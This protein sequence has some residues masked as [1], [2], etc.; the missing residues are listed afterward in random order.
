[1][2]KMRAVQVSKKGGPLELVERDIPKPQPGEVLIKVE[3]CGVCHSDAI[4]VEGVFPINYPRIPGHEVA[5]VIQEIGANVQ[6]WEIGQRVGVG[7]YGGHCGYCQSCRRGKFITC[8]R[9]KICGITYDGGYAE[10]MVAPSQ[11]LALIPAELAAIEAGPL[12]CAGI[13]TFNALRNSPAHAGDLVAILGIGGLGHLAV[14]FAVKMGFKVAAI[15]RGKDKADLAKKLGAHFYI[16]STS[17]NVAEELKKLKGAKVILSTVTNSDA[18][19]DVL[20]GLGTEG[21]FIVIGASM[22]PIKVSGLQL[23]MN[24]QNIKG[25]ASGTAIDSEDTMNFSVLS[26]IR[27]MNEE[28]SLNDA[29]KA[30]ERMMSGK[31]RFRVV[32]KV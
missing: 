15:A 7:W 10:Y 3:A 19:S 14:Q 16:D 29:A 6:G 28:F 12:L 11:A 17:Q 25:W 5:G 2:T 20:G 24:N 26:D 31:A 30:Y 32:L 9:A 18:M 27:S 8:E 4:V 23:L 22:E 13:T 21:T 1:M